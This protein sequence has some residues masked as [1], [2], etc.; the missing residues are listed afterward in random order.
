[1]IMANYKKLFNSDTTLND[2][3]QRGVKNVAKDIEKTILE[4]N[5]NYSELHPK[6]INMWLKHKRDIDSLSLQSILRL[7]QNLNAK[8]SEISQD[9]IDNKMSINKIDL[10][11]DSKKLESKNLD[12]NQKQIESTLNETNQTILRQQQIKQAFHLPPEPDVIDRFLADPDPG[13]FNSIVRLFI[14]EKYINDSLAKCVAYDT[15]IDNAGRNDL[16]INQLEANLRDLG[17]ALSDLKNRRSTLNHEISKLTTQYKD[18]SSIQ[19]EQ[20]Q[21]RTNLYRITADLELCLAIAT[22][23]KKIG[24]KID[25]KFEAFINAPQV[26]LDED[27]EFEGLAALAFKC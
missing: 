4:S 16:Q 25:E 12:E 17:N 21:S 5:T 3:W 27:P 1:M 24:Y 20:I 2:C 15:V 7:Y 23:A 6:E 10:E 8:K 13:L 14:S 18:E 9:I 22:G 19:I 11:I 26:V